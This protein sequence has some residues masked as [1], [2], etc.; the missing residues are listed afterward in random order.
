MPVPIFDR[1]KGNIL[2]ARGFLVR[3]TEEV[4]R[5]QNDLRSRL[6][7]AFE[8]F[9][10]NR[11]QVGASRDQ[12]LP[13]AVRTYRG[14]Y[15]RHNQ[16]PEDVGFADVVV[17][18]QNMLLAVGTYISALNGQWAAFVDIA[19]LLQVESLKE[20]SLKLRD[21]P[22][23]PPAV[24]NQDVDAGVSSMMAH[25]LVPPKAVSQASAHEPISAFKQARPKKVDQADLAVPNEVSTTEDPAAT[26]ADD[27]EELLK[28]SE[29][30]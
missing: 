16:A 6:A 2:T 27:L 15:E 19:A 4:P 26:S 29:S 18:Q 5:V 13:D 23:G 14:T 22:Q 30:E 8:R 9:E 3:A 25:L 10:T 1:N 28:S 20:L 24:E 12:I 17:A 7:D 11:F 21:E